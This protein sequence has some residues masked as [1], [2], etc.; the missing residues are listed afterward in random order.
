MTLARDRCGHLIGWLVVVWYT[1][2]VRAASPGLRA[3]KLQ[4]VG[5]L[6]GRPIGRARVFLRGLVFWAL[7]IT[8][9][10]LLIMLIMMLRH[11]RKQGWHDLAATSVMIKERVLA[12]PVQPAR[13]AAGAQQGLPGSGR[14][15]SAAA[16][17]RRSRGG[18]AELWTRAGLRALLAVR[19]RSGSA[20]WQW[21][22]GEL[23][24]S[25]R[26]AAVPPGGRRP[27]EATRMR[28]RT[29]G[30][31]Y[32]PPPYGSSPSAA[33]LRA[34]NSIHLGSRPVRC[35]RQPQKVLLSAH[36]PR[37]RT[38]AGDAVSR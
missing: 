19:C 9:I 36:R 35:H 31:P 1:L 11:P 32:G 28:R 7:C 38:D 18:A 2:A 33:A 14:Q 20:A 10:G 15:D 5:F 3:M 17:E 6:D 25:V 13:A 27:T 23:W 22:A 30:A 16:T 29:Q 34:A 12:P 21:R 37:T 4:V 26:R 8:G 24:G